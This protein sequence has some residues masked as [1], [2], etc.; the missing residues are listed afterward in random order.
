MEITNGTRLRVN[1]SRTS[2]GA[3][4]WDHT[5]EII[6]KEDEGTDHEGNE[7]FYWSVPSKMIALMVI[8]DELERELQK[9]YGSQEDAVEVES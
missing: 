9:R 4:S 3:Y 1:V 5:A 8:S 2:K 6:I 7:D